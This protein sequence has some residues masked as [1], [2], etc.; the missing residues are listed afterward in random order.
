ME[1]SVRKI[2]LA[3]A[4]LVSVAFSAS[5]QVPARS[6]TR[7]YTRIDD[8]R[9]NAAGLCR[10]VSTAGDKED[11]VVSKRCPSGPDGWPVTMDFADARV[12]VTFGRQAS[13]GSTL[14]DALDGAFADPNNVIEW[15]M[16]GGRPFAAIHRYFF[17][18]RQV[19]TVHRLQPAKTS[20]VAAVVSPQEGHDANA[21]AAEIAD[22]I[23]HTF[24]CGRDD[25]VVAG[26]PRIAANRN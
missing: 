15:R 2:T 17:D 18:G 24:R 20:C 3:F 5:A 21:E 9:T 22:R 13:S 10:T 4:A 26:K 19:L 11:P 7:V 6:V 14:M 1:A 8:V 16:S 12:Y 23:G 25:L